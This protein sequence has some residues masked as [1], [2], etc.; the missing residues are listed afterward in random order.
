MGEALEKITAKLKIDPHSEE[1]KI[2]SFIKQRVEG[3]AA[4]GVVVGLSGGI[5]SSVVASLCAKAIGG[6]KVLGL[7]MSETGVTSVQDVHDAISVSEIL[8]IEFKL[9]NITPLIRQFH[10]TL[11][12]FKLKGLPSANLK[13]RVRMTVLYY[14]AN[15]L[16]RLVA[17]TGNRSEL[18]AGYFTKF[19]DGAGDMLPIGGL[20][21]T[22][23]RQLAKHLG[24]PKK[25]VEKVPT[26]GLWPGQTDEGELGI[27]Y[28]KL[29][30]VY[31]GLD[32]EMKPTEIAE[33]V[34][35]DEAKVKELIAREKRSFHKLS[36][37]PIP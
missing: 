4:S 6:K 21:K 28:E 7:A 5:D 35:V 1:K 14:H 18:R 30:M 25:V 15:L 32:L 24:L 34:G 11:K 17:A 12:D 33:A 16:N 37:P 10:T 27:T 26:A 22:Q 36:P 8:G 19:G 2:V 3:S 23:V 13:P 29:D 31:A 20:Y 9:M